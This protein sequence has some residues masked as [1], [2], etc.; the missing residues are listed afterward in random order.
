MTPTKIIQIAPSTSLVYGLGDDGL[1]YY[2]NTNINDWTLVK[3]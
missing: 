1:L 3:A 2:W